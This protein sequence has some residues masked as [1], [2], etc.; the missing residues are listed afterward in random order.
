MAVFV[1]VTGLSSSFE[2]V[3]GVA[4][5]LGDSGE[6]VV[7]D[8]WLDPGNGTLRVVEIV[9]V[10]EVVVVSVEL[11]V[12]DVK[13]SL[14]TEKSLPPLVIEGS[15]PVVSLVEDTTAEEELG[16]VAGL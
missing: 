8:S 12:L 13:E 3:F 4:L 10:V 5:V 6:V 15:L 9:D 1:L 2:L 11:D 7:S 16:G 14:D